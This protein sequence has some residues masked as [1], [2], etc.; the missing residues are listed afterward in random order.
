M[1]WQ[2]YHV[3]PLVT[4]GHSHCYHLNGSTFISRGSRSDFS[5]LISFF[6]ENRVSKRNSPRRDAAFW[7][8]SV[9]PFPMKRTPGLYGLIFFHYRLNLFSLVCSLFP[10]NLNFFTFHLFCVAQN[11]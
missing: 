1:V 2:V 5:F 3:N 9:C 4:N 10:E 7:E 6:D 11:K 8:Y